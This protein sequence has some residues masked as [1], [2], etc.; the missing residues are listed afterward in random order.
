MSRFGSRR[1]DEDVKEWPELKER[2]KADDVTVLIAELAGKVN[3]LKDEL[4]TKGV[5]N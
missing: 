4:R 1:S 2:P 5:I 3:E